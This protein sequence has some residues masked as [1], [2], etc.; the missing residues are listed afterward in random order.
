M[1]DPGVASLPGMTF[2]PTHRLTLL[3]TAGAIAFTSIGGV[4]QA[5]H[6]ADDG[7]KHHRHHHHH[8]HHHV[9]PGDDR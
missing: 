1:P 8:H 5:K 9:E 4:A 3:V 7:A 2:L 6:G